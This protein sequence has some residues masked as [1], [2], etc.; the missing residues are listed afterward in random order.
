VCVRRWRPG[1]R[2]EAY[3]QKAE[4]EQRKKKQ[5]AQEAQ[6]KRAQEVVEEE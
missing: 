2:E 1:D 6:E 3:V 5:M 4:A